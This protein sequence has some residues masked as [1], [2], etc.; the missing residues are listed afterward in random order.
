MTVA[1]GRLPYGEVGLFSPS[2]Q[3]GHA[4]KC[5]MPYSSGGK[6]QKTDTGDNKEERR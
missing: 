1:R 2:E 6:V 3:A 5:G 4:L